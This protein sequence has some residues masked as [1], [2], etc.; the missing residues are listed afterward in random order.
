MLRDEDFR[1]IEL[2][3]SFVNTTTK[4]TVQDGKKFIGDEQVLSADTGVR[5]VEFRENG[6]LLEVPARSGAA[7]HQ[8]QLKIW[9]V[10][11][12]LEVELSSVVTVSSV[13]RLGAGRDQF[14]VVF[15]EVDS[16]SWKDLQAVF[17][18][19]QDQINEFLKAAKGL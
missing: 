2:H 12:A 6:M 9:T 19:R 1:S 13:E 15:N 17:A 3:L 7:G 16:R 5:L 4:T 11:A 10:G 8:L 18:S 14:E